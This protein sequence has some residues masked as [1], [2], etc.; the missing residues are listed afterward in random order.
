MDQLTMQMLDLARE[1][2]LSYGEVTGF[3]NFQGDPMPSWPELG[4]TIQK[5]WIAAATTAYNLSR[6]TQ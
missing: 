3:R 1:M 2:Y 4:E 6:E 5:A